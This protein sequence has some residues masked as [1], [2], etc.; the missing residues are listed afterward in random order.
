MSPTLGG[1]LFYDSNPISRFVVR[2]CKD[3]RLSGE[4]LGCKTLKRDGKDFLAA[5][6]LE[7]HACSLAP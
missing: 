6:K 1:R 4:P 3:A 2:V 7:V 5:A